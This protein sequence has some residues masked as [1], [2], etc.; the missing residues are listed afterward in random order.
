MVQLFQLN[1]RY[2]PVSAV[3]SGE[4]WGVL[5]DNKTITKTITIDVKNGSGEYM[6]IFVIARIV[7]VH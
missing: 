4:I 7:F 3:K 5:N 2:M 1:D 6:P